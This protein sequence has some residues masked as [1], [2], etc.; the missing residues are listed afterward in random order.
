MI[1]EKDDNIY[2]NFFWGSYGKTKR[3]VTFVAISSPPEVWP[4]H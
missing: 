2:L 3:V 4:V 1:D